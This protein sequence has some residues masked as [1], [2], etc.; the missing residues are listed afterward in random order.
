MA[1]AANSNLIGIYFIGTG[2]QVRYLCILAAGMNLL[3]RC[4]VFVFWYGENDEKKLIFDYFVV[5]II[6]F[7]YSKMF[8]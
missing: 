6:T 2:H 5:V 4:L 3:N 8:I 7:C 1:G